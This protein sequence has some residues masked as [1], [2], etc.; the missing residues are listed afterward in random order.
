MGANQFRTTSKLKMVALVMLAV[1]S[2]LFVAGIWASLA[3]ATVSEFGSRGEGAGQFL[4]PNGIAVA[5][6]S[7]DVY[8][9]DTGNSRLDSFGPEGAFRYAVGWGV[10]DGKAEFEVC[11]AV[12]GPGLSGGGAGEFSFPNGVAVD[13][14]PTSGSF[15]DVYVVDSGNH[16]VQKFDPAGQFLLTFGK[17]VNSDTHE[18]V[19]TSAE[20]T[21]CQPGQQ[22]LAPGAFFL[23]AGGVGVDTLGNIFVGDYARVEEFTQAGAFIT[24]WPVGEEGTV[25]AL[26][27]NSSNEVYAHGEGTLGVHRYSELGSELAPPVDTEGLPRALTLGPSDELFVDNGFDEEVIPHLVEFSP[28]GSELK[29]FDISAHGGSRGIAYG[30]G[31]QRV[32]VLG[33]DAVRLVALPPEGPLVAQEEASRVTS[34]LATLEA[35]IDAEG[36]ATHYRFEYGETTAYGSSSPS[37]PLPE[38]GGL[39][40]AQHASAEVSGL[41]PSTT[42]HFRAVA[43][44][45]LGHVTFGQDASIRTLPP[46]LLSA[47]FVTHVTP[48]SARLNVELNPLGTATTYHFEYGLSTAYEASVPIPDAS[49]GAGEETTTQ[50]VIVE[51][52][53]ASTTYHYRVV[54]Q[55]GLGTVESPDQTFTTTG[56]ESLSLLDHRIWE[57]VS[58]SNKSGASLEGLSEEGGL[59][60]AAETGDALTYIAK[61]PV[62]AE[63]EG[64]R[65][66]VDEQLL[67][68]RQAGGGWSTQDITTRHAQPA[69]FTPGERPEYRAFSSELSKAI[70]VPEGATPL[71]PSATERTP[72]LREPTGEFVPL[73]TAANVPPGTKFGGEEVRTEHFAGGVTVVGASSDATTVALSAS[74]PLTT[75]FTTSEPIQSLYAWKAGV[76]SLV[77]WLPETE[78][79]P[80]EVPAALAGQTTALG[81]EDKVIRHA[82]SRDNQRFIYESV[83]PG[84][85]PTHLYWRDMSLGKSLQL[86]QPEAGISASG[87]AARVRFQDASEDGD[88]VFF[89]DEERLTANATGSGNFQDADLYRCEVTVVSGEPRCRLQNVTVPVNHGEA[90]DVRGDIVGSDEH[91]QKVYFV[92]NGKLTPN[93]ADGDCERSGEGA[94]ERCNL[95]MYDAGT[96]AMKLVAV[97]SGSDSPDWGLG[98]GQLTSLTARVSP[99]GRFAAFM[100]QRSLTGYDNSDARSGVPDEEVFEY[101]SAEDTLRCVSCNA[102]GQRPIGAFDSGKYPGLLVDRVKSW[103]EKWLAAAI[104]GWQVTKVLTA[105]YQSRYLT[106]DGRLFFNSFDD[107]VSSD[108]N[109][110]SDV[111]EFEPSRTGTCEADDGCVALLSSGNATGETAFLDAS[112]T[113]DDAF[114]LTLAQLTPTDLDSA[115]DVYDAHVCSSLAPCAG[116]PPAAP[117]ACEDLTSCRAE[118][119]PT[120]LVASPSATVAGGGNIVQPP[121]VKA[122]RLTR[123]Q[124]LARA[125]RRCAKK[126]GKKR[127]K[128]CRARARKRYGKTHASPAPRRRHR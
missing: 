113:G 114:F 111:Y 50:S 51:H 55:N 39:F 66:I 70:L 43:E 15:G 102:T 88:V 79:T 101:D 96:H 11:T 8:V 121:A 9:A 53:K 75:D 86:D 23:P 116:P 110:Q 115:Y 69:G 27:V 28:L 20:A 60:Q 120:A 90:A 82:I 105:T 58:P 14:N 123:A 46:A 87:N 17:E 118:G 128:V 98:E 24:E 89:T 5:Q 95:Y 48:D 30:N 77:G 37:T 61:A 85:A 59:I 63:T 49:A 125:L 13:N 83:G 42:Y 34:H 6:A 112:E 21:A 103:P 93:A 107:L 32:Y 71:A 19:C 25:P 38:E 81:R 54:A 41:K 29:A 22:E 57:E 72:Y 74:M 104:P 1:A 100:S 33:S 3:S 65:S 126:H 94:S 26:A 16:R 44:D 35:T 122:K 10:A 97:L 31:V 18:D 127:R 124:L 80:S 106:N 76:I 78:E 56:P 109:N 119:P 64:T 36:S 52:L 2:S 62:S 84:G 99:N 45:E 92:A 7:G 91:G 117:V 12:C 47:V 73:V 67:A 68:R 40:A 108:V 4:E